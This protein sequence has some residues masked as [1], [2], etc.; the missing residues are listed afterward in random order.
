MSAVLKMSGDKQAESSS[1]EWDMR[2]ILG[3]GWAP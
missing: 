3:S 1:C 2:G